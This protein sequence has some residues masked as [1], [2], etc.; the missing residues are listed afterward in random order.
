MSP[1]SS[2]L[3]PRIA[4]RALIAGLLVAVVCAATAASSFAGAREAPITFQSY[5]WARQMVGGVSADLGQR[6]RFHEGKEAC[7][8]LTTDSQ[9]F[10]V[11][12]ARDKFGASRPNDTCAQAIV[13]YYPVFRPGDGTS[14][15]FERWAN[16]IRLTA[17]VN[18]SET[19]GFVTWWQEKL[20]VVK[21]GSHWRVNL[22]DSKF[23]STA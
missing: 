8:L 5:Q 6:L 14:H 15:D 4:S 16:G 7:A 23:R 12:D 9:A 21:I 17:I 20:V 11:Q 2:S 18:A 10:I 1:R 22:K 19:A 3:V 13:A